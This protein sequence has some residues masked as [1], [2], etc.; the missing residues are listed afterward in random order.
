MSSGWNTPKPVEYEGV[1]YPSLTALAKKYGL[2]KSSVRYRL[3]HGIPLDRKSDRLSGLRRR[4]REIEARGVRYDSIKEASKAA[5]L[6][7][8]QIWYRLKLG[9]APDA[10]LR[11]IR[12]ACEID[13][14]R[15]ESI[16]EAARAYHVSRGK[17][18]EMIDLCGR[19][20]KRRK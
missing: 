4:A 15:Y 1:V 7:V 18:K 19:W 16:A 6:S 9:K 17:M 13:G 20:I 11:D 8:C 14:V 12:R 10:K 2:D 3:K 5:G